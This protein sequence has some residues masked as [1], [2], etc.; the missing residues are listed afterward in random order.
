MP[1]TSAAAERF[2]R[3]QRRVVRT[4]GRRLARLPYLEIVEE[5]PPR[6]RR[7]LRGRVEVSQQH[8]LWIRHVSIDREMVATTT[9]A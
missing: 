5:A 3:K 4:D 8:D 2:N 7:E 6:L 1:S 9:T